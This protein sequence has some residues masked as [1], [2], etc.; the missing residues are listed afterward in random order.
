MHCWT[1]VFL[2]GMLGSQSQSAA[3]STH[4]QVTARLEAIEAG[5]QPGPNAAVIGGAPADSSGLAVA[6]GSLFSEAFW[7]AFADQDIQG[8][9]QVAR[10]DPEAQFAEAMGLLASGHQL[11]AE[12]AFVASGHIRGDLNVAV[13][14][15]VMLAT[16]LRAERKWARLRDL[17]LTSELSDQDQQLTRDLE[18]WG[19]AFAGAPPEATEFPAGPTILRMTVTPVGTPSVHVKINGKDYVFWIDTGSSMTVLS[20]AV[21]AETGISALVSDTLVVRTFAGSAPVK[22][23][24]VKQIDIGA[25]VITNSP[26]VIIDES[27]MYLRASTGG[28]AQ[29]VLRVDGLI[30]WDIIRQLDLTMDY[31][32]SK[33]IIR[34]PEARIATEPRNLLWLGKPFVELTTKN[35]GKVHFTVDTG[36]QSTFI[37]EAA[38]EK[39]GAVT[40]HA[41]NRVFGIARTTRDTKKVGFVSLSAGD[42]LLD[43]QNIIV[44]GPVYSGLIN[45][46]GILG[47]DIARFGVIHIDASNGVFSVG[48]SDGA[49]SE[50]STE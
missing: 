40:Q 41:D 5:L 45:C 21:A 34:R 50:D 42:K 22:A 16:T 31:A 29:S 1:V 17:P 13:A 32:G 12:S 35:G 46:D 47:S 48:A 49:L 6:T 44:Y 15:Q 28:V 9:R 37:N 2:M 11:A 18:R 23:A 19:R 25:I 26:A 7:T 33:A 24:V 4:L 14:A 36:A 43:L 3:A 39:A 27:L 8:L 38:V 10:N 30:G 20:S